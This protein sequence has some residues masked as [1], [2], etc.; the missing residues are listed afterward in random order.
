MTVPLEPIQFHLNQTKYNILCTGGSARELKWG[1]YTIRCKA[2]QLWAQRCAPDADIHLT[3]HA[4][5]EPPPQQPGHT[6][7][8]YNISQSQQ[9]GNQFNA[10]VSVKSTLNV[11][12]VPAQ[13]DEN[14][15]TIYHDHFGTM[16]VDV[17]DG[18]RLREEDIPES[19]QVI[20]QSQYHAHDVFPHRTSHVVEHWFNSYPADMM[21]DDPV[22]DIPQISNSGS[23]PPRQQQPSTLLRMATVWSATEPCP[24]LS[25]NYNLYKRYHQQRKRYYN[26][27][28]RATTWI[29]YDCIN[30]DYKIEQWYTEYFTTPTELAAARQ[31]L[32]Q[33]QH[34]GPGRLYYELFWKFDVLVVPAKKDTC[35]VKLRYGNVQRAVSQ[36][37]S[38]VPV[39]LEIAGDVLHDFMQ[40]YQYSCVFATTNTTNNNSYFASWWN[41]W[42]PSS[43][44]SSTDAN[45][46][47]WTFDEAVDAMVQSADLRKQCQQEGLRIAKDFTPSRIAQ[48]HLRVLGYSGIFTC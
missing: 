7:Y 11:P 6:H 22:H 33:P 36:F 2:L 15:V 44:S 40:T 38:G 20:V 12:S 18:Y 28:G 26:P 41:A 17:V 21:S 35:P 9:M 24:Q 34:Y 25:N 16:F 27:T 4:L 48:K 5:F 14:N 42:N 1:S 30:R 31:L 46:R 8:Y 23:Q 19:T 29:T 3:A 43:S 47:Y 32:N 39:L 13:D 10:T 37:R 45:K